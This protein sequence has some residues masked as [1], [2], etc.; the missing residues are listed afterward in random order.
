MS[1]P[2]H[3]KKFNQKWNAILT[4]VP[5]TAAQ[6]IMIGYFQV[7]PTKKYE[8]ILKTQWCLQ[9]KGKSTENADEAFDSYIA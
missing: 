3:G 7:G 8:N 1:K 5:A 9:S 4:L 6:L 2:L